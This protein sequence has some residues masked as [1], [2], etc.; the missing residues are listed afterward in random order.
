MYILH[1]HCTCHR[2]SFASH[3]KT[4]L[5]IQRTNVAKF[6]FLLALLRFRLFFFLLL[7]RLPCKIIVYNDS[8]LAWWKHQPNANQ[9]NEIVVRILFLCTKRNCDHYITHISFANPIFLFFLW[10]CFCFLPHLSFPLSPLSLSASLYLCFVQCAW[11]HT[12]LL[13]CIIF[14]W[15]QYRWSC[16][17]KRAKILL[18]NALRNRIEWIKTPSTTTMRKK[19]ETCQ[20]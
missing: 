10:F 3:F 17:W 16:W 7:C 15:K 6:F 5:E 11:R 1:S 20:P 8:C 14:T 13:H 2:K 19:K 12:I 9:C 18:K 4:S